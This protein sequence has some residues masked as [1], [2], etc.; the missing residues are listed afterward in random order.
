MFVPGEESQ[1]ESQEDSTF[2]FQ[3]DYSAG[4]GFC[5]HALDGKE[6]LKNS[7]ELVDLLI[8]RTLQLHEDV[9]SGKVRRHKKTVQR[10]PINRTPWS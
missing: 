9:E 2:E 1:E 3:I 5:W 8:K 4:L 6:P 7:A 10:I